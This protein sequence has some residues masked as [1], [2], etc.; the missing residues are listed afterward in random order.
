MRL[1]VIAAITLALAPAARAEPRR[2]RAAS[3]QLHSLQ[4]LAGVAGQYE[5]VIPGRTWSWLA[6][7]GLRAGAG[8]GDYGSRAVS[9]SA[10]A[11]YWLRGSAVWSDLPARSMVGWFVG[12]RGDLAWTHTIDRTRD[13]G[14]GDNLAVAVTGTFGYRF[15]VRRVEVTPAIGLG[16]TRE[17]DLTG[18]MP[19]WRRGTLRL[20]MTVGWL[21]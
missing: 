2:D 13:V 12:V 8:G 5:Q 1:A 20:G 7:G 6:G 14:I 19:S 15:E 16:S 17:F 3:L 18:R 11:R 9:V 10:E 21:F 4:G